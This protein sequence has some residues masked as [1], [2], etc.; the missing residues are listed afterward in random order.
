M[1]IVKVYKKVAYRFVCVSAAFS[2]C[3]GGCWIQPLIISAGHFA[4]NAS[5][6]KK[7]A[8]Y[9]HL[10]TSTHRFVPYLFV[11]T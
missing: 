6:H 2:F 11:E 10:V 3:G 9:R 4:V 7:S 1:I 8:S 5:E